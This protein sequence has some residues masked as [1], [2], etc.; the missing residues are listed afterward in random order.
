MLPSITSRGLLNRVNFEKSS[1]NTIYFFK[2][3]IYVKLYHL[4]N[5]A[6]YAIANFKNKKNIT[7]NFIE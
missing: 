5:E 7:N 2:N 1:L 4:N 3:P 6:H